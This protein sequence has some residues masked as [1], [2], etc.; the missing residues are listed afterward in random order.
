MPD[1]GQS[2]S[3]CMGVFVLRLRL[4]GTEPPSGTISASGET[5]AKLFYGWIELMSTINRLRGW[6]DPT[7]DG[8]PPPEPPSHNPD[9]AHPDAAHP[10]AEH[11]SNPDGY[12]SSDPNPRVVR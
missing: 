5:A 9:A 7:P 3:P 8:D 6:E 10:D 4:G 11:H 1:D 12:G 2:E